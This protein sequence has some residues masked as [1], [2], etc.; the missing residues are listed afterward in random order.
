VGKKRKKEGRGESEKGLPM[1][2]KSAG[3]KVENICRQGE[4]A[5]MKLPCIIEG[6][7]PGPDAVGIASIIIESSQQSQKTFLEQNQATRKPEKSQEKN[8]DEAVSFP[9]FG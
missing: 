9:V 4:K 7:W 8:Q 5:F 6:W 3:P 1:Q 2:K